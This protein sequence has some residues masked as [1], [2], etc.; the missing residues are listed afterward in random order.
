M[1]TTVYGAGW[2]ETAGFRAGAGS[3]LRVDV[4]G[5]PE[6]DGGSGSDCGR[7]LGKRGKPRGTEKRHRYSDRGSQGERGGGEGRKAGIA[8]KKWVSSPAS[9]ESQGRACAGEGVGGTVRRNEKAA[10]GARK[11]REGRQ[12]QEREGFFAG[13]ENDC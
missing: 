13:W 11:R 3:S 7:H 5:R 10:T 6:V 4:G 1:G 8:G 12:D 9:G 2:W